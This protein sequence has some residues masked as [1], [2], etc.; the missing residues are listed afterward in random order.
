MDRAS[1]LDSGI[2]P[3]GNNVPSGREDDISWPAIPD[4]SPSKL[5]TTA[6]TLMSEREKSLAQ[7]AMPGAAFN[8]TATCLAK[9]GKAD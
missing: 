9:N 6:R 7:P 1:S 4:S 2:L 5:Q 8:V 3:L